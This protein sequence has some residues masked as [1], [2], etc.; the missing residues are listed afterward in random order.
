MGIS[1]QDFSKIFDRYYRVE[2]NNMRHISGF[3]IGLYVSAE[4]IRR[5]GRRIR[6]ESETGH[7]S[8]FYF[9]LALNWY[10][11]I[12][13][14]PRIK[15]IKNPAAENLAAKAVN[16]SVAAAKISVFNT[17]CGLAFRL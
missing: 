11:Q 14:F 6:A 7:A 17:F 13:T 8:T 12:T 5:H 10:S 2:S 3:G 16:F 4:I 9:S 15:K 1:P